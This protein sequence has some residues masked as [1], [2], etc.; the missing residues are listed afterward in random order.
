M[1]DKTSSRDAEA[2]SLLLL[3]VSDIKYRLGLICN[4]SMASEDTSSQHPLQELLLTAKLVSY[5][6]PV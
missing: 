6:V 5:T 4:Y 1:A 2:L 3:T